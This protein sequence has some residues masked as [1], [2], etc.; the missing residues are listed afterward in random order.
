[1]GLVTFNSSVQFYGIRESLPALIYEVPDL[2]EV[3]LPSNT[4]LMVFLKEAKESFKQ[5][6]R[7]LPG[8]WANTH[9]TE[10]CLGM[11]T[12]SAFKMISM[13]GGRISILAAQ[14]P[15]KGNGA[16]SSEQVQCIFND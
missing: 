8:I 9:S 11:A 2:E 10:S 1:M 13:N 6:L 4:N 14:R 15:T 16:L 7:D 5:L 3:F 12:E